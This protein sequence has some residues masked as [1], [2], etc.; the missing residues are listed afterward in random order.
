MLARYQDNIRCGVGGI[1]PFAKSPPLPDPGVLVSVAFTLGIE[2]YRWPKDLPKVNAKSGSSCESQKLPVLPPD[3]VPP[4]VVAD[5][6]ANPFQY[7]NQGILL[8]SAGLKEWLFGQLGGV[9]RNTS[10]MGM[11]G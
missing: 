2:R 1:A 10:Q 3:F 5:T 6:G 9:P 11:P 4:Y 8:N 7:G